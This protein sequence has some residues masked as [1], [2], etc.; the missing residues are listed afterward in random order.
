MYIFQEL[1]ISTRANYVIGR[2]IKAAE[3]MTVDL[4]V[5]RL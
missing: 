1:T 3:A 4:A 2:R 5:T